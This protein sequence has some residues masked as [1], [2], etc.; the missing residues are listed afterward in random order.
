MFDTD[1]V[2]EVT[3]L[4]ASAARIAT[5]IDTGTSGPV[6]DEMLSELLAVG[7]LIDLGTC[8]AVERVD[9]TGQS[10]ADGIAST[11]AYI[12]R[13]INERGEWASKR[14]AVGRA[15]ADRL[16]FTAKGW[17]AGHLGLEHACVID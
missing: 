10:C 16:P 15:L 11:T 8:R 1:L 7:R 9:R 14:V 17:E 2:A 6:A 4:Q 5:A 3:Q 13:R 12:R